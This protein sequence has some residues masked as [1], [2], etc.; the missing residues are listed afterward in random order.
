MKEKRN[1]Y[2]DMIRGVVGL[3]IIC[4]HTA[5]WC[6]QSYI[7]TCFQTLTL[8]IDV[9]LFFFLSRWVRVIKRVIFRVRRW[10]AFTFRNY[11]SSS[12]NIFAQ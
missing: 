6:G 9:S 7:P 11:F 5:F 2:I 3:G 8:L 12:C 1:T 10:Y 4:I